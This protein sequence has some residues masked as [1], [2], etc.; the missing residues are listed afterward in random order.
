MKPIQHL[1]SLGNMVMYEY[2][3]RTTYRETRKGCARDQYFEPKACA[4]HEEMR[5]IIRKREDLSTKKTKHMSVAYS[6]KMKRK[7][8]AAGDCVFCFFAYAAGSARDFLRL[9]CHYTCGAHIR[10]F[11]FMVTKKT[12]S[13][14]VTYTAPHTIRITLEAS[15]SESKK[16]R[17][18]LLKNLEKN[19]SVPGFR[20]GVKIPEATLLRH[21]GPERFQDMLIQE[22]VEAKIP[23]LVGAE[24]IHLV[25]N[26][27]V[28]ETISQEPLSVIVEAEVLPK[29]E[30]DE[31]K[32]KKISIK[33]TP[34]EIS[35][36]D[37]EKEI[38]QMTRQ[39]T[40]YHHAGEHTEDGADT[41]NVKVEL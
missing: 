2:L 19:V 38:A 15:A 14:A 7:I 33:A 37:V 6:Q 20:P 40:H 23:A 25:G 16:A 13:T 29:I 39:M 28:A 12:S 22:V 11:F 35:S 4:C 18:T 31:K 27:R 9:T 3:C 34:V 21:V 8:G 32:L 5:S 36:E 30:I 10:P 26:V 24:K 17:E 1:R 41:S